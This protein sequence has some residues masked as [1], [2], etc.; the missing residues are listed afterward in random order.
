M[1]R[2]FILVDKTQSAAVKATLLLQ[3]RESLRNSLELGTEILAIMGHL[4]DGTVFTDIETKFGLP[5][6]KGQTVFNLVNGSVGSML[7]SFQVPDAKN[8]TEILGG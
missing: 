1:A 4:N 2:D 3:Y 6:G 7:G 8:L 5:A